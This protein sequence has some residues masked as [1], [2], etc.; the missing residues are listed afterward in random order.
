MSRSRRPEGGLHA[1]APPWVLPGGPPEL[2]TRRLVLRGLRVED[3][4]RIQKLAG[5]RAIAET[6]LRVPH[7]YEDGMAEGWIRVQERRY[8][9][10]REVV[11]AIVP[12]RAKLPIG[13]IHLNVASQH[14]R[15]ELGYWIGKPYWNRGYATEAGEAVL[16]YGFEKIGLHRICANHFARNPASGRVLEKLGMQYEGTRRQHVRRWGRYEDLAGYGILREEFAI[17]Q[18][19]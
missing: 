7:P 9:E 12:L 8:R 2:R 6:T 5:D 1:K 10:G 16:R 13:V 19:S 11:F 4:S 18:E 17:G 3:A 15:A 14:A